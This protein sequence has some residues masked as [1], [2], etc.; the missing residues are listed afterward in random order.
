[1]F[2]GNFPLIR[3]CVWGSWANRILATPVT[4][5]GKY[6]EMLQNDNDKDLQSCLLLGLYQ[7]HPEYLWNCFVTSSCLVES[8][9]LLITVQAARISWAVLVSLHQWAPPWVA[10]RHFYICWQNYTR[11]SLPFLAPAFRRTSVS[12]QSSA[13]RNSWWTLNCVDYHFR[14]FFSLFPLTCC[15]WRGENQTR[16]R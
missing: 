5:H 14:F 8:F 1:M 12:C 16:C 6:I 11:L 2:V 9:F 4:S 13:S 10:L 7:K 3:W 15:R